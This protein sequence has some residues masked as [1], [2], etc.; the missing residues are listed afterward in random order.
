MNGL[1][2]GDRLNY[3][4]CNT[5]LTGLRDLIPDSLYTTHSVF[6]LFF[7]VVT[8]PSKDSRIN[9]YHSALNKSNNNY[10]KKVYLADSVGI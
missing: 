1:S 3:E 2:T 8:E 4:L 10:H 5:L 6:V 9:D 7:L